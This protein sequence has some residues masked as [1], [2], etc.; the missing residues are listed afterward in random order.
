MC[1]LDELFQETDW[2]GALGAY[3]PLYIVSFREIVSHPDLELACP[4]VESSCPRSRSVDFRSSRWAQEYQ[5]QVSVE[6]HQLRQGQPS[7]GLLTEEEDPDPMVV[8][9]GSQAP[10]T[11]EGQRGLHLLAA[12]HASSTTNL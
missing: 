1:P 8:G 7:L 4:I 10:G 9:S 2:K 3:F 6:G 11:R 5:A 12:R